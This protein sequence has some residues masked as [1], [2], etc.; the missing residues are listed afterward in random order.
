MKSENGIIPLTDT[1]IPTIVAF[2]L[3]SD[4]ITIGTAARE[5]GLKGKTSVFNFKLDLGK[6]DSEFAKKKNYWMAP[7]GEYDSKTTLLTAKEATCIFLKEL[8]RDIDIPEQILIGEPAIREKA[9][10]E[11]FRRHI[12][13]IFKDINIGATPVFFP[14]PFAVFQYYR[15]EYF[16]K[17]DKSEIVLI[18]DIGGGTF[19]TGIIKTTDDGYL[20][21]GG[22]TSL[23][24]GLQ[25]EE[26]GGGEVD[27]GLLEVLITK[28]KQKGVQWK[29]DPFVR[30]HKEGS[31]VMLL[32]ED[33]KIRLS[34]IIGKESKLINSYASI[35]EQLNI[36]R[37]QL[38]PTEEIQIEITGEDLKEVIRNLWRKKWGQIIHYTI[39]ESKAKLET[40]NINFETINRVIVAGGS[41][42]LPFMKEEIALALPTILDP[43]NI[44]IAPNLGK[45]VAAGLAYE[46][47]EQI[48]RN[49]MLGINKIAPCLLSELYLGVRK[50]RRD[51]LISPKIRYEGKILQNGQLISE[52]FLIEDYTLD[53]EFEMPFEV[54][55]KIFYCFSDQPFDTTENINECASLNIGNDVFSVKTNNK[56]VKKWGLQIEI[57]KNG[58][59]KPIFIFKEKGKG[60]NKDGVKIETAEFL[61]HNFN[62]KEGSSFIG[63]DFGTS[64]S[65]VVKFLKPIEDV[66]CAEYPDYK[67]K[68]RTTEK[69]REA[70]FH[71]KSYSESGLFSINKV[72][73]FSKEQLLQL[74]FHSN[75]IE[76]SP[77]TKGETKKIISSGDCRGLNKNQLEA[78]NL[79]K[80]YKWILENYS[81]YK[82]EPQNFIRMINKLILDGIDADGGR[83]RTKAVTLSGM[84]YTPPI[85]TS[86]PIFMD[87]F[88]EEL[89][90]EPQNRSIIEY[91]TTVHTKF[92]AIHP[93]TDGNGRS[94][95]L[96]M[97]AILIDNGMPPIIV[98]F[99]DKQRYLSALADSN[100][101]DLSA[102]IEFFL[103]C[104]YDSLDLYKAKYSVQNEEAVSQTLQ[105]SVD[106]VSND[107]YVDPIQEAFDSV[108]AIDDIDPIAAA[109]ALKIKTIQKQKENEY[110]IWVKCF[111]RLKS[112]FD[113]I[114]S[115][116]NSNEIYRA[117]GF[118]IKTIEYDM[119]SFEKYSDI[120]SGNRATKTWYFAIEIVYPKGS[121]RFL[122]FFR[123]CYKQ[124][125]NFP[126][127]SQVSLVVAK[128]INDGYNILNSEPI[129]LR[130]ICVR[131]IDLVFFNGQ[132]I[133][134][135]KNIN[136]I[137]KEFFA[138]IIKAYL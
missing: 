29:D 77:L 123:H 78:F 104:F 103:E 129:K 65:Y 10:R 91:A 102:M 92:V 93:F 41:A 57:K 73:E 40:Q 120:C 34:N 7:T 43:Q 134:E 17:S 124:K 117:N 46:C 111:E 128:Y 126:N 137:I 26:C 85:S 25:A 63:V 97:T 108:G 59:I 47:M 99:A 105:G 76:G 83:Y 96:L 74:V 22:G 33:L 52:P 90:K 64:N 44:N 11:N 71:F 45:S 58:M 80:A 132:E 131:D 98:N 28:C 35:K 68:P 23:P 4:K 95:R 70:E 15:N 125:H 69:L 9:W 62:L 101:G 130:E 121:E 100:K 53:Y 133:I 42:N 116:F 138:D 27:R 87:K 84:D 82:T 5:T 31:S 20:S 21:R 67:V 48:N 66:G 14:E 2:S 75:K 106:V 122:F 60:A 37:G 49:P 38:H 55:D 8:L 109:M 1:K 6:G 12:R 54:N 88:S 32:I 3:E 115:E 118:S 16:T 89:R 50:G 56:I 110:E 18:I 119:L 19:N 94:A 79:E 127:L 112:E 36:E 86:V 135:D 113:L 13:D 24:L 30:A 61:F 39:N 136:R 107:E 72:I 51:K 81:G 114:I